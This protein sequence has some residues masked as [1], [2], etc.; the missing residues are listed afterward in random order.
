MIVTFDFDGTLWRWGF[1]PEDGIFSRSCGP[2]PGALTLV[3]QWRSKG[4]SVHIVTSRGS[5]N[6]NEVDDFTDIHGSL[7][8]GVHFT[9][10]CWKFRTLAELGSELH[11]DDDPEELARLEPRMRGVLWKTGHLDEHN[12]VCDPEDRRFHFSNWE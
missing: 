8:D 1:D 4:A 10:G 6:R 2:D 9:E 11:F 3:N 7:F 5:S 12:N